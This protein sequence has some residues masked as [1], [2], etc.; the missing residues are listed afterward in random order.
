M[1]GI[2]FTMALFVAGLAFAADEG[3]LLT[4]AKLGILIASLIAGAGGWLFLSRYSPQQR[5]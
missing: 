4:A 3:A 1:A 5:E 2:G